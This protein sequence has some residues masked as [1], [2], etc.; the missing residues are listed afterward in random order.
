MNVRKIA[1]TLGV[2]GLTLGLLGAGVGAAF[3]DSATAVQNIKVGTFQCQISSTTPN[4]VVSTDK[5]SVTYNAADIMTSAAGTSPFS[6]TVSSMGTIPVLVHVTQ[7]T[8]VTP[9][10]SLLAAPADVTLAAFA[11][12]TYAAGLQ[13]PVLG[14]ADLGKAVTISYTANC[15]EVPAGPTPIDPSRTTKRSGN[16]SVWACQYVAPL[17]LTGIVDMG[18]TNIWPNPGFLVQFPAGNTIGSRAYPL[19]YN[20]HDGWTPPLS[21]CPLDPYGL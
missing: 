5:H 20:D 14:S 7:T 16:W 9:F 4:A 1:A 10:T 3:T 12:T 21:A 8:P 2:A 17:T 19:A 15:G 18:L 11:S 13:W 6:F